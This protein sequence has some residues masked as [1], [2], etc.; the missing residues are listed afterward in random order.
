MRRSEWQ[1]LHSLEAVFQSANIVGDLPDIGRLCFDG[2]I[3][4]KEK[5][6]FFG[7]KSSFDSARENRFVP[8]EGAD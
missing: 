8:K 5:E 1:F 6:L 3:D 4:F 7:R 2:R